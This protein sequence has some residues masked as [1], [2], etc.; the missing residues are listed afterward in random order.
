MPK[1]QVAATLLVLQLQPGSGAFSSSLC[2]SSD[3]WARVWADEFNE[4][5]LDTASWT[6]DLAGGDSR[7]RDSQG[8]ADN[9]YLANGSLVLR[10]QKEVVGSY[11]FSSGAVD[12]QGKRSFKAPARV[13]VSA[14]LPGG[15]GGPKGG[16]GIWPAHWLMPD[17][18]V[19]W[20]VRRSQRRVRCRTQRWNHASCRCVCSVL[21]SPCVFTYCRVSCTPCG[22]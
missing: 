2:D 4:K 17:N 8:T 10:S 21:F 7:V 11:N 18:D 3:S 9:V 16:D 6:V 12:S 13:C 1:R 5:E 14:I 22:R 15:T 20:Y 19:C